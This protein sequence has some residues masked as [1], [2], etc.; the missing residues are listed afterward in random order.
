MIAATCP[1]CGK[2]MQFPESAEGKV[3]K[4]VCGEPVRIP[5]LLN[6]PAPKAHG[7]RNRYLI[8]GGV[9][10]AVVVLIMAVLV[11]SGMFSRN[12]GGDSQVNKPEVPASTLDLHA[13]TVNKLL[14][15]KDDLLK[16][17][18]KELGTS[19]SSQLSPEV[20]DRLDT[21][22]L[23]RAGNNMSMRR[24][25]LKFDALKKVMDEELKALNGLL[26]QYRQSARLNQ[27]VTELQQGRDRVN[28][29]I[30]ALFDKVM[31][32]K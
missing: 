1:V 19:L 21:E 31:K 5:F 17:M 8:W 22:A 16:E 4:C 7:R 23:D 11:F 10:V 24:Y 27:L 15:Q 20:R 29:I 6:P 12:R 9:A 3:G 32:S 30:D 18:D 13:G 26:A 2:T 14:Y 25:T 28:G